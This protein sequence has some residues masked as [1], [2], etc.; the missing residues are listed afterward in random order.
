MREGG[1]P[2]RGCHRGHG[3]WNDGLLRHLR[4]RTRTRRRHDALRKL[5]YRLLNLVA[6][7]RK[8][9]TKCFCS[10]IYESEL[11][12]VKFYQIK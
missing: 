6:D 3:P 8:D 7:I 9:T 4:R 1:P 10:M 2:R 11:K 5:L 12:E